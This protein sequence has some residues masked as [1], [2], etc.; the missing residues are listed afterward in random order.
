M[1]TD[2]KVDENG[3]PVD[4]KVSFEVNEDG[5]ITVYTNV[6]A[7]VINMY[8]DLSTTEISI[9]KDGVIL[10]PIDASVVES[11]GIAL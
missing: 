4:N 10:K 7:K 8:G 5:S 11:I 3:K 6:V 1:L 2:G 9:P